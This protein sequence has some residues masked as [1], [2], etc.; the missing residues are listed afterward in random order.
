M[1]L[2][3]AELGSVCTLLCRGILHK[4][5]APLAPFAS[6]LSGYIECLL[7]PVG[8]VSRLDKAHGEIECPYM[9]GE[10]PD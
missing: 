5:K 9:L 4:E 8:D 7:K 2:S 10:R 6:C 3:V 1:T